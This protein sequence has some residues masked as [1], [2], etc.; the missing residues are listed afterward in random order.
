MPFYQ[1]FFNF[2]FSQD[3]HRLRDMDWDTKDTGNERSSKKLSGGDDNK[4]VMIIAMIIK[5][6]RQ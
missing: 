4:F 1:S 5:F 3:R 2:F 6:S